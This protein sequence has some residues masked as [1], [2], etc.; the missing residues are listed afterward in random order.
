MGEAGVGAPRQGLLQTGGCS[1]TLPWFAG[2]E[3][4]R[5]EGAALQRG[6]PAVRAAKQELLQVGAYCLGTQLLGLAQNMHLQ[7]SNIC[8]RMWR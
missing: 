6:L 4:V 3:L 2:L 8:S 5:G 7:P 1:L